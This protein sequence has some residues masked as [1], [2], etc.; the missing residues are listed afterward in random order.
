MLMLVTRVSA[1]WA[2]PRARTLAPASSKLCRRDT[3]AKVLSCDFKASSPKMLF[4]R[5]CF[6]PLQAAQLK[7]ET[8]SS[9]RRFARRCTGNASVAISEGNYRG[10]RTRMWVAVGLIR[11]R[12]PHPDRAPEIERLAA[13]GPALARLAVGEALELGGDLDV[14]AVRVL[15]HETCLNG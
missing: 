5:V 9:A 1:V 10:E 3:R 7:V 13:G 2:S 14:V 15:D 11:W 4:C 12:I 6:M 8:A